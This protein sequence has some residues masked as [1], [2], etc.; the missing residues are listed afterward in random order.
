MADQ[1]VFSPIADQD[2]GPAF[3]DDEEVVAAVALA[4][5]LRSTPH[6]PYSGG[7]G[8]AIGDGVGNAFEK[9]DI[10]EQAEPIT[11]SHRLDRLLRLLWCVA[12]VPLIAPESASEPDCQRN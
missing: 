1:S 3:G 10:L 2:G 12:D 11:N 8:E 7:A 9:R 4:D 6:G 5:H